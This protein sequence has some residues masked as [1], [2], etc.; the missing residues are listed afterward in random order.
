MRIQTK[1]QTIWQ[2]YVQGGHHLPFMVIHHGLLHW[3][4]DVIVRIHRKYK[5][6]PIDKVTM[7]HAHHPNEGDNPIRGLERVAMKEWSNRVP[8]DHPLPYTCQHWAE[9]IWYRI[10][11]GWS[12]RTLDREQAEHDHTDLAAVEHR[13]TPRERINTAGEAFRGAA[14]YNI[15]KEEEPSILDL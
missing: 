12:I 1:R 14:E 15:D 8:G 10:G 3:H 2:L 13:E 5:V 7:Y 4:Y 9:P 11:K 6:G